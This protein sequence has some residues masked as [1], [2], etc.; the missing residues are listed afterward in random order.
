MRSH[1]SH[2][3]IAEINVT[4]LVDIML[5]LLVIFMLAAPMMQQGIEVNLPKAA[6]GEQLADSN[7]VITLTKD[8]V[9]YF[10][11]KLV[12]PA[13]LRRKLAGLKGNLP[14]LIRSDR[15]AHVDK[16][17]ELWDLCR[18]AGFRQVHI[19]TLTE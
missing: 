3:V 8:Q 11:G 4:P 12:T 9:I 19:T 15:A 1:R 18:E 14:I 7:P 16:L 10:N 5:V 17:V 6:T 13:A 2:A